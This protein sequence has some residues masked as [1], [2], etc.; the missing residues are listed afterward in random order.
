MATDTSPNFT[1]ATVNGYTVRTTTLSS[2]FVATT[3]T[4]VSDSIHADTDVIEN[5]KI[6]MGIDIDVAYADVVATLILQGSYNGVDWEDVSA[7]AADTTPNVTGA[8]SY[9]VDLTDIYAPYF[10][11]HF[12]PTGL[13]V[14]T[15]GTLKFYFAYN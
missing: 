6:I 8:Q 2:T 1:S 9:L 5:K 13:A 7:I 4:L 10:R 12:N 15:S 11:L 3:D 14:G